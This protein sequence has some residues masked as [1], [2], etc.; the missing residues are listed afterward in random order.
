MLS[1]AVR[2]RCAAAGTSVTTPLSARL[3]VRTMASMPT[4]GTWI[5]K[6]LGHDTKLVHAAV[7]PDPQSGAILTPIFQSTTYIQESIEQYLEP[8]RTRAPT[9][10]RCRRS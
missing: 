9:T 6:E 3:A 1:H 8:T 10:R 7:Q 5:D 2:T 4:S